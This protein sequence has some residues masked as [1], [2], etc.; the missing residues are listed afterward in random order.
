MK[1]RKVQTILRVKTSCGYDFL[2]L[3]MNARRNHYWQNVTGSVE[4]A[5]TY[6]DAAIREAQ[7][8]TGLRS[9]N[10]ENI[11]PLHLTYE[12]TDQWNSE[13]HEEVFLINCKEKWDVILDPNEHEDYKWIDQNSIQRSSVY[14]QSNFDALLKAK[15]KL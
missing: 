5:E 7:E 9:K 15:L 10:I 4:E 13:V 11:T 8:E 1:K 2:I 6:R 3:Q 14:Y 12:F